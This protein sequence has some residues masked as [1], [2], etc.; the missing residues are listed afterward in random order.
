[1]KIGLSILRRFVE[2]PEPFHEV[3]RWMDRVGLEVKRAVPDAPH[4]GAFTLELL[5]NRGDH[6]CY[7][8]LAREL[9]GRLSRPLSLPPIATLAVGAPPHP[10]RVQ[11]DKVLRYSLTELRRAPGAAVAPL[12][13]DALA[14]LDAAESASVS[15]PVDATNV[16]N[17]ELGQPTHAFD[18]DTIVGPVTLRTSVAGER[19][20]LLFQ[21]GP[22]E[23]PEGT[24]V[25]AD[26][27]KILAIAGVIGC[28]ESKTTD[29]TT[30]IL[31]ESATFDP[32]SV[33]K[34]ARALGV[35]TDSSARFERGADPERP[36]VGA[37]RVVA[38]LEAT[39]AWRR[40]GE[41]GLVGDWVNPGRTIAFTLAQARGALGH[42]VEAVE[43]P[44]R[45]ERYGFRVRTHTSP[46]VGFQV[47]VPSHRLWD[48]EFPADVYEELAKSI[49]YENFVPALPPVQLG[50]LPSPEEVAR[51]TVDDVL[52]GLGFWEIVT[53]GF[54]GRPAR[55]LL[56][57]TPTHPLW[58]HVETTNA[59]DRA[60]SLL[61]NNTLHQALEAIA[62]NERRKTRNVLVYEWTRT[63][64]PVAHV[65][66]A[67]RRDVPPCT[68]R[69][70]LWLATAGADRPRGWHDTS[71][72]ADAAFLRGVLRELSVAL[73]VDLEVA[74]P[75]VGATDAHPAADRL[76]P[77]RSGRILSAGR[78]VGAYGEVHPAIVR[79][80]KLKHAVP[81]WLELEAS[82]LFAEGA[83]PPFVEPPVNQPVT[84]ALAFALPAGVEAGSVATVLHANGP[85]AL[86][87]VRVVDWF[88]LGVGADGRP[89]AAVTF[90]LEFEGE[91]TSA[92][93]T[94]QVLRE[95]VSEVLREFG[96]VGVTQR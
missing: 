4:G 82:A 32:V 18:A 36:L 22:V 7:E 68:E 47:V 94:N 76:H 45:L 75:A 27:V 93:E 8:G 21:P 83:R 17:L 92:D 67:A 88:D 37:G 28:E 2:L 48:V 54:Y 25:V 1:M 3:R 6:H 91:P 46:E 11:T 53:D 38:L 26:D 58:D 29:A 43:V 30:R 50:A 14:V 39:G 19:A 64:H 55:E 79:A 5:A 89:A 95:L 57:L 9:G 33:R 24:L 56:G 65:P 59:L 40:H 74:P 96:P 84:R 13:P 12:E 81:C 20:W 63:F 23:V 73:G 15:P 35:S 42:L 85:D 78:P 34:A 10:V 71:R 72:P 41:V 90:E 31:L 52:T 66:S 62:T 70:V 49:G 87:H 44:S 80:Y 61:K 16:A 60:Y 86:A 77:G 69:K 51:R